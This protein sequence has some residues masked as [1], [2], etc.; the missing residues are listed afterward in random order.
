MGRNVKRR[1]D[2]F[3]ILGVAISLILFS[4]LFL[5]TKDLPDSLTRGL[6]R[7]I[8]QVL[9]TIIGLAIPISLVAAQM[10][11]KYSTGALDVV[12]NKKSILYFLLLVFSA[13]YSIVSVLHPNLFPSKIAIGLLSTCLILLIPHF[14]EVKQ[15]L[16]PENLFED[17]RNKALNEIEKTLKKRH[18]IIKILK[19]T[20]DIWYWSGGRSFPALRMLNPIDDHAEILHNAVISAYDRKEYH[21][22]ELGLRELRILACKIFLKHEEITKLFSGPL[23]HPAMYDPPIIRRFSEIG[24]KVISSKYIFHSVLTNLGKMAFDGIDHMPELAKLVERQILYLGITTF[25]KRK[26]ELLKDVVKTLKYVLGYSILKKSSDLTRLISSHIEKLCQNFIDSNEPEYAKLIV[27]ALGEIGYDSVESKLYS[28]EITEL[29]LSLCSYAVEKKETSVSTTCIVK[30][31]GLAAAVGGKG[32]REIVKNLKKGS[33]LKVFHRFRPS[34]IELANNE[35][36]QRGMKLKE[37]NKIMNAIV[38]QG[39]ERK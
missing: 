15:R 11:M 1:S 32:K 27:I 9:A 22:A 38:S 19:E 25:D 35:A 34:I 14:Y 4:A 18:V 2:Q 29:L 30:L 33:L 16:K 5:T 31:L 28:K 17:L 37:L 39:T 3:W 6:V 21:V 7:D 13:L 10:S 8:T 36:R 20:K 12:F 24:V 23:V 26:R